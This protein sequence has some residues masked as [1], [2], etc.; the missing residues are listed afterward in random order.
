[1]GTFTHV[2]ESS[3]VNLPLYSSAYFRTCDPFA[4]LNP[5][6]IITLFFNAIPHESV[7]L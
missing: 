3:T 1:M 7:P 6:R 2:S 5:G 4:K